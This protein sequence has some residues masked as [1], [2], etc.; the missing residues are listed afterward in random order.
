MK[1]WI[2]LSLQIL[3][4]LTYKASALTWNSGGSGV[5]WAHMC[6]FPSTGD[7]SHGP[8][9]DYECGGRC[10]SNPECTHFTWSHGTCYLKRGIIF[11][12]NAFDYIDNQV[13]CGITAEKTSKC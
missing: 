10:A 8:S 6:D 1:V 3:V 9:N 12:F 4:C 13:V 11:K 5:I 2:F 7:F